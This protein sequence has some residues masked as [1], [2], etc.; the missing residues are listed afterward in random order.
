MAETRAPDLNETL[1]ML[2]AAAEETRFRVLALL[3]A[4]AVRAAQR[5]AAAS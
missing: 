3:L 5:H 4:N 2:R 1:T